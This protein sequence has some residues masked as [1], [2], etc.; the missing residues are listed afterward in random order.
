MSFLISWSHIDIYDSHQALFTGGKCRTHLPHR[1]SEAWPLPLSP[2]PGRTSCRP[3]RGLV[4]V[5]K[6]ARRCYQYIFMD[7]SKQMHR[8]CLWP[9]HEAVRVRVTLDTSRH[10]NRD[11]SFPIALPNCCFASGQAISLLSF[12]SA[13][14]IP[15]NITQE[16]MGPVGAQ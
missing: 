3:R 12:L 11:R 15:I 8:A 14:S 2:D 1:H 13:T 9:L 5:Q 6:P 7:K 16:V 4:E 10:Q